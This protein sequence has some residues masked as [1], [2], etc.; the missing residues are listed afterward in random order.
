MH[1]IVTERP[2]ILLGWNGQ[3]TRLLPD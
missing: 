1:L 2:P 3:W